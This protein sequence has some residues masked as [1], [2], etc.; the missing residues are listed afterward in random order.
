M[1]DYLYLFSHGSAGAGTAATINGAC[2]G[3][4]CAAIE[5]ADASGTEWL[6]LFNVLLVCMFF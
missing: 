2:S 1:I 4:P 6:R 3:G 5:A